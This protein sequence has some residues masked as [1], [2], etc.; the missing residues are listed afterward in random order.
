[1]ASI[2]TILV[3]PNFL[4]LLETLGHAKTDRRG[5]RLKLLIEINGWKPTILLQSLHVF[6]PLPLSKPSVEPIYSSDARGL[7]IKPAR[8]S[9]GLFFS[10]SKT[11]CNLSTQ[12]V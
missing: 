5:R 3:S 7:T 8:L 6:N 4:R 2:E 9:S 12:R 10:T 11:T 1:M